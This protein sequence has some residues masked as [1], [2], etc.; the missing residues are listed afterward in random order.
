M[1]SELTENFLNHR[2]SYMNHFDQA[3]DIIQQI[4]IKN[5]HLNQYIDVSERDKDY[6]KELSVVR[7]GI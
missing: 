3:F 7:G 2:K 5:E 1:S 4:K 6:M